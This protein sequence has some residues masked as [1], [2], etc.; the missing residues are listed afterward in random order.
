MSFSA[1]DPSLAPAG[2]H[3]LT[4]WSQ[5]HPRH[6]AGGRTWSGAG[7]AEADRIVA[8]MERFA[9][10][11]SDTIVHR[12]VHTPADLRSIFGRIGGKVM[13]VGICLVQRRPCRPNPA[14]PATPVPGAHAG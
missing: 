11:F 13:P 5:W 8:G 6:L 9:P 7:D 10:G 2:R 14:L 1:L 4:L 3:E 12:H